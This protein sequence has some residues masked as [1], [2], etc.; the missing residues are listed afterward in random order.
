MSEIW[1]DAKAGKF[2]SVKSFVHAGGDVNARNSYGN[3]ILHYA[4]LYGPL[5]MVKYLVEHGAD[6]HCETKDKY[7]VLYLA[8]LNGSLEIVK[9]LVENGT[10]VTMEKC[11]NHDAVLFMAVNRGN[12]KLVDYLLRH[13]AVKDIHECDRSG[14]SLLSIACYRG[15]VALVQTLLKYKVDVRKEKELMCR[16]QDIFN[17][18]NLE[19]KKS[20]KHRE[21]IEN[22]KLLDVAKL[23]VPHFYY[24]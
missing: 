4:A 22:L 3:T 17:V 10:K 8:T 11:K 20:I 18:I 16:N 24:M 19:L 6:V 21:K 23:K 14:R 5:E 2:P 12:E 1:E 7:S 15:N 9:Y 13:G